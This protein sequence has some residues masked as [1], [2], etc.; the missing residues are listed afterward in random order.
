MCLL[1]V[2]LSSSDK[3]DQDQIRT[4][5]GRKISRGR[6]VLYK[7]VHILDIFQKQTHLI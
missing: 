6:A 5:F 1:S 3:K 7:Y 2:V 4:T